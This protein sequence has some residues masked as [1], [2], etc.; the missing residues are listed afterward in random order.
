[1]SQADYHD[2]YWALGDGGPQRDPI[3]H[4]QRTDVLFGAVV[5]I[6][7]PSE[8]TGYIIPSDNYPGAGNIKC[9]GTISA[10][11]TSEVYEGTEHY[12]GVETYR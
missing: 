1:M 11:L 9:S 5:R 6:S 7:V 8:G 10:P 12:A 3:D 2:L 4:G